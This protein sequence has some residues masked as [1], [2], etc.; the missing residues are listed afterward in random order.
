MKKGLLFIPL[1]VSILLTGCAEDLRYGEQINSQTIQD[2]SHTQNEIIQNV[3]NNAQPILS[4]L[5]NG[6]GNAFA[7]SQLETLL[8]N[9]MSHVQEGINKLESYRQPD[10]AEDRVNEGLQAL[11]NY[12]SAILFLREAHKKGEDVSDEEKNLIMAINQLTAA[13]YVKP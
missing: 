2:A 6:E 12:K 13:T 1:A 4:I 7:K 3:V 9:E 8:T 11:V 10:F 5:M